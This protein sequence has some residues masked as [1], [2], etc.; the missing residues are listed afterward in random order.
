MY[1]EVGGPIVADVMAGYNGSILA[2]GQTGT[3]KTY[4]MGILNR[5]TGAHTG[6]IPRGLSHVFGMWQ[7]VFFN[8]STLVVNSII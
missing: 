1:N 4:T 8:L 5:V 6:I 7:D 2:Y 3:G